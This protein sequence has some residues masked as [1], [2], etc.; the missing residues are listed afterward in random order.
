M[1][2]TVPCTAVSPHP[3]RPRITRLPG[4][5]T[6]VDDIPEGLTSGSLLPTALSGPLPPLLQTPGG[7]GASQ[8][9]G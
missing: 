5:Q 2:P 1:P 9:W 6:E 8:A 3:S 4:A 7:H